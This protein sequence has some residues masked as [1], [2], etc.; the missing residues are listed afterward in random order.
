MAIVQF[1]SEVKH[2]FVTSF[3]EYLTT[4]ICFILF[5]WDVTPICHYGNYFLNDLH[6]PLVTPLISTLEMRIWQDS[7]SAKGMQWWEAEPG[8]E[9]ICCPLS[10]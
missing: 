5:V 8:L 7:A 1:W 2:T 6:T 10:F 9:N 3:F 4:V